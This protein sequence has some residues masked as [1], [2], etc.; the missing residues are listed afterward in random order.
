MVLSPSIKVAI[1]GVNTSEPGLA[2][3]GIGMVLFRWPI[4]YK[5]DEYNMTA[6]VLHCQVYVQPCFIHFHWMQHSFFLPGSTSFFI[7]LQFIQSPQSVAAHPRH[8]PQCLTC[9][10]P[11][12]SI[13]VCWNQ[14]HAKNMDIHV[15]SS[16][17]R[18][19]TGVDSL[20]RTSQ[21]ITI[22][23]IMHINTSIVITV[24][25]SWYLHTCDIM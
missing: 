21:I 6:N 24:D 20:L 14:Y 18:N 2:S 25:T 17:V 22:S 10:V 12:A 5:N 1:P 16:H 4:N 8:S 3:C 9:L 7:S 11:V 13:L 19:R 15:S 23:R